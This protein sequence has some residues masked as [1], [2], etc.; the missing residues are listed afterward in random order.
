M[1]NGTWA[2][3]LDPLDITL[4]AAAC[5]I[6]GICSAGAFARG[7]NLRHGQSKCSEPADNL[8]PPTDDGFTNP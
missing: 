5:V 3:V 8:P 7:S 6:H 1:I 2:A 4:K